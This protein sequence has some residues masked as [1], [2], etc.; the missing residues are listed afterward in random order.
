MFYPQFLITVYSFE[1]ISNGK[2][3]LDALA[4]G[5]FIEFA[6]LLGAL[7]WDQR[8]I[9]LEFFRSD[10]VRSCSCGQ[11]MVSGALGGFRSLAADTHLTPS[12]TRGWIPF[13]KNNGV[14]LSH[15]E[16]FPWETHFGNKAFAFCQLLKYRIF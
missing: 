2:L 6:G 16:L 11:G 4:L 8:A 3:F 13:Q 14:T 15:S 5:D 12:L 7:S 1:E 9:F 10:R